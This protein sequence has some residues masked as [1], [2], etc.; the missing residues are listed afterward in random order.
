MS[1]LIILRYCIKLWLVN[2]AFINGLSSED[3]HKDLLEKLNS[4]FPAEILFIQSDSEDNISKGWMIV[5][6]NGLARVEFEPPNHHIMVADGKWLIL[7]DARYDR[8]SYLPIDKGILGALLHPEK[9]TA[10]NQL[11]ISKFKNNN[12]TYYSVISKNFDGSELKLYFDDA[13][14]KLIKWEIIE[15]GR[16]NIKVDISKM[17]RLNNLKGLDKNIF[18]FPNF[19]RASLRGFFGPFD[20]KLKKIP[21]SNSN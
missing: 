4:N 3:Y 12:K 5:G 11:N 6:R 1:K 14:K 9:F 18:K 7:H 15:N 2:F 17:T 8:T 21:T 20:R 10:L 13:E 16:L 19:M